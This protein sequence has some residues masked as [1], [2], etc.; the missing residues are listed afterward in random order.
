MADKKLKILHFCYDHPDNPWCGGGG[1]RRT[2]A[3]NKH[4]SNKHDITVCCGSFPHSKNQM[5]PFKVQ[6][7]GKSNRYPESRLKYIFLSKKINI[8]DY[9]L[10]V[11]DFSYYSPVL[12]KKTMK[13]IVTIVHSNHGIK[14]LKFHPVYGLFSLI[15]QYIFLPRKK[16][17]ILVSNHLR[18]AVNSG[19]FM[20]TIGQG[21]EIP[22]GL[23]PSDEQFVLYIGR[24]DV[25]I[26]GIDLL[27][28]AWPKIKK[29][30]KTLPLVIAGSGD[31]EKVIS[32]IKKYNAENIRL[33]GNLNHFEALSMIQKAAFVCIP[34][35]MEGS[36]LVAY[37]S[38]ALGKPIVGSSIPALKEIVP[39]NVAG[40]LFKS[41]STKDLLNAIETL[42]ENLE[43]RKRLAKGA[44][45]EGEKYK[46]SEVAKRQESFYFRVLDRNKKL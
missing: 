41:E 42:I 43:I 11:D 31:S 4:L 45:D 17:V 8:E 44:C 26:K 19:A 5:G 29:K 35:R 9:N 1:A 34:S 15:S 27:L 24:L 36:P 40:L 18:S 14:A 37:E 20:D 21:V 6:F 28:E 46:W 3:I 13:P 12:Y 2:W 32:L 16:N 7:L 10:I 22:E 23:P 33:A 39:H 25:K 38:M 30:N